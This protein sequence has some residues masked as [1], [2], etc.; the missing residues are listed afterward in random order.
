VAITGDTELP[1]DPSGDE[2]VHEPSSPAPAAHRQSSDPVLPR[3]SSDERELGWG[4]E[5]PDY[6][7]DWYLEQRP[8]HHE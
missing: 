2:N 3:R 7:D 8:P 4:D 6:D 5:A 1:T